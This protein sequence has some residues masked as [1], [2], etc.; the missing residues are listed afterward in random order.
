MNNQD[1]EFESNVVY[2][3]NIVS[4]EDDESPHEMCDL[5]INGQQ[6]SLKYL[7]RKLIEFE[8]WKLEFKIC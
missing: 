7:S 1:I 2:T 6:I 8:G 5:E 4:I 3:A